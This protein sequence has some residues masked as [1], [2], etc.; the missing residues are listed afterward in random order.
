MANPRILDLEI[1]LILRH[2]M[3]PGLPQRQ[4]ILKNL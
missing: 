1:V 2:L 4:L 3:R